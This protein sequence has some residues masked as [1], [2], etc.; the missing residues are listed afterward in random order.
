MTSVSSPQSEEALLALVVRY[1]KYFGGFDVTISLQS[2]ILNQSALKC[3][4]R[5]TQVRH[6]YF[7]HLE[8]CLYQNRTPVRNV[9]S[10]VFVENHWGDTAVRAGEFL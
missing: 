3:R 8:E 10:G 1:I 7:G 4:K 2:R 5:P 9:S 6:F